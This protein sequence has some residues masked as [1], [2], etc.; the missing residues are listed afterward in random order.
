MGC[1]TTA[2]ASNSMAATWTTGAEI[3]GA[4]SLGEAARRAGSVV[5]GTALTWQ[6][7]SAARSAGWHDSGQQG[8]TASSGAATGIPA[9]SISTV[10]EA[11]FI[12]P[13]RVKQIECGCKVL[14][15]VDLFHNCGPPK[16]R[17]H[18]ASRKFS[19]QI[20]LFTPCFKSAGIVLWL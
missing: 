17:N 6:Q 11:N 12:T 4:A 14:Q 18:A 10:M 15:V 1:T 13:Y 9:S 7:E 8:P 3:A 20:G 2:R 16:G 5:S 19:Q